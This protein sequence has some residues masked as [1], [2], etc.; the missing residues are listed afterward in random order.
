MATLTGN[1][2]ASTYTGLLSVNGAIST[3]AVEVVEDGAGTDTSLWLSNERATI[4]LGTGSADDFVILRGST[5]ILKVEGDTDDVTLLDDLIFISDSAVVKFGADGDTTLTHTD[6]TGLTLNSTNKLCFND[7]SQ[8]VQG[9]RGT[10]LSIGATDEID[11]TAT[12]ID[13]NGTADVSGTLTIGGVLTVGGN[14]DFNSGT[15]DLSTQTVDVTLNAAVDALNFDSNTLSIDA[16]NNRVGI[17]TA[18][19]QTS[20]DV[21][22]GDITLTKSNTNIIDGTD[23]GSYKWY[24]DDNSSGENLELAAQIQYIGT[25]TWDGST[26]EANLNF[27]L[28]ATADALPTTKMTVTY[29]GKVGVA[30]DEPTTTLE[31]NGGLLQQNVTLQS[32]TGTEDLTGTTGNLIWYATTTQAGNITLPQATSANAGMVIKIIAGANWAATAFK[33]G[34]A[35]GGST[36]MVGTLRVSALDAVLTTSFAV[37]ANTKNLVIDADAVATAGGAKGSTYTF[38]Y[39]AANLV[40]VDANAYIT[41]GTVAT[42][43][44]AS[45][46]G[47]I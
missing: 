36:V 29:D 15:I 35:S 44:A 43:A 23:L 17:G 41:T 32:G 30:T 9:S 4:K 19:P 21:M 14:I 46:T 47:G 38:T 2:I 33:L 20:F 39:L 8:F 6:G 13:I 12:A 31:V 3:G 34:Y 45:V 10:V 26:S 40:H 25:D 5:E 18:S 27:M 16:T 7:A 24:A 11:L 42:T 28:K 37:T 22:D 1:T